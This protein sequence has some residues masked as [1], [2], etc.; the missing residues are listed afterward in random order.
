[1]M[2][3]CLGNSSLI[4]KWLLRIF[5]YEKWR[6]KKKIVGIGCVVIKGDLVD[7]F[8]YRKDTN[9]MRLFVVE[10]VEKCC[11]KLDLVFLFFF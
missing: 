1:M 11:G 4:S 3:N 8:F 10:N 7:W 6:V 9:D 5:A 2:E